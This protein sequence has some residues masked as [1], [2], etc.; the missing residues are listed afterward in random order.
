MKVWYFLWITETFALGK[1]GAQLLYFSNVSKKH[2]GFAIMVRGTVSAYE[3]VPAVWA[4]FCNERGLNGT[5]RIRTDLKNRIRWVAQLLAVR[6][7]LAES[8][9]QDSLQTQVE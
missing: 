3:F 8:M 5:S 1:V 7:S 2:A 9:L 6:R 4:R